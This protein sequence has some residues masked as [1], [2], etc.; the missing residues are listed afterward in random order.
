MYRLYV[1]KYKRVIC[2]K[3]L[4]TLYPL[5]MGRKIELSVKDLLLIIV[6]LFLLHQYAKERMT[7]AEGFHPNG[8]THGYWP[9]YPDADCAKD[10]DRLMSTSD[11]IIKNPFQWPYSGSPCVDKKTDIEDVIIANEN[12]RIHLDR[13]SMRAEPDHEL[14]Q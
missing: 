5:N 2:T 6:V 3:N 13:L 8:D 4:I 10:N 12:N 1:L 9:C 14:L 11:L 7:D